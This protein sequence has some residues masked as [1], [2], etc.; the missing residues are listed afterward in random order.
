[1]LDYIPKIYVW[2]P[3]GSGFPYPDTIIAIY[4]QDCVLD[5]SVELYF[6]ND[7]IVKRKP[8]QHA[9]NQI[10]HNFL[11]SGCHYLWFCDDDNPPAKDVLG[12]MLS[13]QKECVSA[14]VPLRHGEKY[15]LN[16][17][18][19]GKHVTSYEGHEW[20]LME[21]DNF[22]T[23]CVLMSREMVQKMV[24]KFKWNP[25]QFRIEEF[26]CKKS[27]EVEPY[28]CQDL[29]NSDW[30]SVYVSEDWS[31]AKRTES[32]SEDLFFGR[33]AKKLGFSFYADLR[34]HCYHYKDTNKLTVKYENIIYPDSNNTPEE[35]E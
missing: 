10:L 16:V 2:M 9:R 28:A 1:M 27:W 5:K 25:Y 21:I 23:G 15:L 18:K 3:S 32:I 7:C 12:N 22:W 31:I 19:D 34:S 29:I 4:T 33:E 8:V 24:D 11:K 17:F 6:F 30:Q 20:P 35:W 14:L 13:H 26:V